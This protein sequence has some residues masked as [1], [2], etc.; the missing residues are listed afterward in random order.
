MLSRADY[1]VGAY[2]FRGATASS[3]RFQTS[4]LGGNAHNKDLAANSVTIFDK[5]FV[6]CPIGGAQLAAQV[7]FSLY[8]NGQLHGGGGGLAATG[9]DHWQV[10]RSGGRMIPLPLDQCPP[11]WVLRP[12]NR[13]RA[14]W[15]GTINVNSTADL[16]AMLMEL[17]FGPFPRG[18]GFTIHRFPVGGRDRDLSG[19]TSSNE[20]HCL[21]R[22]L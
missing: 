20:Y 7:F 8:Q 13:S 6:V 12:S 16:L 2:A 18:G 9:T 4:R 5:P 22:R 17:L 3:I 15:T 11:F 1:A 10:C 19:G 14:T 21:F